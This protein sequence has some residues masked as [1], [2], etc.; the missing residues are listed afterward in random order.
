MLSMLFNKCRAKSFFWGHRQRDT[1]TDTVI[2]HPGMTGTQQ[3]DYRQAR[4]YKFKI[5]R[6]HG[7]KSEEFKLELVLGPISPREKL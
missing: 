7:V 4:N 2:L 5:D 6:R 1:D 3:T